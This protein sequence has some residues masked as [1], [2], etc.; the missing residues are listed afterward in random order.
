MKRQGRVP[1]RVTGCRTGGTWARARIPDRIADVLTA[2]TFCLALGGCVQAYYP[3]SLPPATGTVLT[4]DQAAQIDG[5]D[6]ITRFQ[7]LASMQG[8]EPPLVEQLT[9]PVGS[10]NYTAGPVPVVR[11]VFDN[12][13][14]FT[15]NSDQPLPEAAPVFDFVAENLRRDVPDTALTVL[16]HTDAQGGDAYNMD[17]SRRR[18]ANVIAQLVDR[19]VAP[20]Q[21]SEV[22]IGKRQPIAPNDTPE[23]RSRNRRVEFLI[24]SGIEANLAVVKSRDIPSS[25]LSPDPRHPAEATANTVAVERASPR[26]QGAAPDSLTPYGELILP[27]PLQGDGALSPASVPR[28]RV[29]VPLQEPTRVRLTP[30]P[31]RVAPTPKYRFV[32]LKAADSPNPAALNDTVVQ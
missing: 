12:R 1:D 27:E 30:A 32:P 2:S 26:S 29:P 18:A 16:G 21:L 8:M 5:G 15:S 20:E 17:L 25:Y 22:G 14:F 10:V 3:P 9:L 7:R 4:R 24:S 19:G 6:R 31:H 13:V 23:G 28:P 11:V